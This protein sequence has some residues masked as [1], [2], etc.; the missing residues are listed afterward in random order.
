MLVGNVCDERYVA[1]A[2]VGVEFDRGG[3]CVA[4][5]RAGSLRS[6]SM[7]TFGRGSRRR[8]RDRDGVEMARPEVRLRR[9]P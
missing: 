9:G 8:T 2:E 1:L 6:G 4:V 3:E 5:V 7:P